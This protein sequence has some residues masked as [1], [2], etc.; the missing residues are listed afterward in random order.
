MKKRKMKIICDECGQ[1]FSYPSQ[2]KSHLEVHSPQ[3]MVHPSRGCGKTFKCSGTLKCH[4]EKHN[5]KEYKC[6]H[7]HHVTDVQ[8]YL[9]YHIAQ[10]HG[11]ILVCEYFINGCDHT[12]HHRSYLSRHETWCEYRQSNSSDTP[13]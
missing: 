8:Y 10:N 9:K 6:P 5:Q 1:R 4:L 11:S 3:K 12:T 2:L 13:E 7:C